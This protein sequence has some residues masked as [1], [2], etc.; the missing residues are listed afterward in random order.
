MELVNIYENTAW[1]YDYD[2]RDNLIVDIP[3]YKEYA[4]K[5]EGE[6]LELGCG[7][8]RVALKLAEDGFKVTGLDLSDNMLKVFNE[9]LKDLPY[10]DNITLVNGNMDKFDLMKK[11]ELIIAPFRAFQALTEEEDVV[12]CLNCIRE[13]LSDKGLFIINVFRPYKEL[14]ETWCYDE[15]IQWETIDDN[16]GDKIVKKHWG[17]KIDTINQIIFPHFAF[18]IT[19]NDGN[20]RRVEEHLKLKYYYYNQIAKYIEDAGLSIVEKYGWYDKS[21]I[22]DGRELIFVCKK[23]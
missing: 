8:G 21:S 2:N 11:F 3:F 18:E 7:T 16:T 14:D 9:K 10:R 20:M 12:G 19:D 1:L 22:E 17:D 13:H 15:V 23:I 4:L 5:T 6:V